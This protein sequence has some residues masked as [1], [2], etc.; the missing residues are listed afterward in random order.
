MPTCPACGRWLLR[1]DLVAAGHEPDSPRDRC[2]VDGAVADMDAPVPADGGPLVGI[3]PTPPPPMTLREK[4]EMYGVIG[5]C[6]F[7]VIGI[8]LILPLLAL[9]V[10]LTWLT[11]N[12]LFMAGWIVFAVLYVGGLLILA[13]AWEEPRGAGA[14]APAGDDPGQTDQHTPGDRGFG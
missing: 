4:T 10:V 9:A 13:H 5:F 14:P 7:E 3:T 11:G 6:A 2:P 12:L 1:R 8:W